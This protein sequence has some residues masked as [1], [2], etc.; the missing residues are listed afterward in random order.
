MNDIEVFTGP[1]C[2]YCQAAKRLLDKRGLAFTEKDVS[3]PA[4]L[5]E[6]QQRL[7]RVRSIPQIFAGGEHIGGFD[8]LRERLDGEL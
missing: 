7:P 2:A 3:D 6:F 5:R 4:V 1:K 8:D